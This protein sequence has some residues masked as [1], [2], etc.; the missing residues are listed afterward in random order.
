MEC[1]ETGKQEGHEMERDREKEREI[2]R[3]RESARSRREET[4]V[5]TFLGHHVRSG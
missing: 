3:E 5:S 4:R 1:R 2:E